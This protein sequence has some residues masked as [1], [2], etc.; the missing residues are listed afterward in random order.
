[1]SLKNLFLLMESNGQPFPFDHDRRRFS[2]KQKL[3][4]TKLAAATLRIQCLCAVDGKNDVIFSQPG[5]GQ[6]GERS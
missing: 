3:A 6:S 1:M 2:R 5:S 4:T